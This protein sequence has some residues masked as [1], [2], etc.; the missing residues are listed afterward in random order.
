M[1]R[2]LRSLNARWAARFWA[3]LRDWA[4]VGSFF[5]SLIILDSDI[6]RVPGT[7]INSLA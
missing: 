4:A 2:S 5:S 6:D 1:R 7:A 3:R